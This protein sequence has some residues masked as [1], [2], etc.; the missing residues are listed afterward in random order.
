MKTYGGVFYSVL[1][2]PEFEDPI[3]TLDDL[4]AASESGHHSVVTLSGSSYLDMF[5]RAE[6][7]LLDGECSDYYRIGQN[8]NRTALDI[9]FPEST[10]KG[11][12]LINESK[13]KQ[14][15]FINTY[16]SLQFNVRSGATREMH[17]SSET[18]MIDQMAMG[19]QRGSPL[20]NAMNKA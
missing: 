8:M 18:L 11:I 2:V 16:V 10:A 13:G 3:E 19:L 14:I 20:L 7:E 17:I 6:C 9:Q 12:Q 4:V 1:T 5:V 15:I